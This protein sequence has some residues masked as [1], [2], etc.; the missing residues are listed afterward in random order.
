MSL[1]PSSSPSALDNRA[2]H[3]WA[4][5][6][7][8]SLV[9]LRPLRRGE[10]QMLETVFAGLST[11]SRTQRYL[12]LT[13]HL[14]S[15]TRRLLADV[16]G[17]N[18]VAWLALVRGCPVGICRYVRTAEDGAEVAFEV[19]DAE[20]GRGLGSVL[21]DAVTTV[22]HSNGIEWLEAVVQ[23]DNAASAAL[24]ARVGV[25]LICDDGVLEGRGRL[26]LMERARVD[27]R[28]VLALAAHSLSAS[29]DQ[30]HTSLT[31][32]STG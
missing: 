25:T 22:A 29:T 6:A 16:D 13:P 26:R 23:P 20:Q 17:R 28:A 10:T 18:H 15:S 12:V 2:C 30:L 9:V 1:M 27:R 31:G 4:R 32:R 7:D 3:M 8:G 5:L 14:L 21:L 24:L 19:I 11:Q